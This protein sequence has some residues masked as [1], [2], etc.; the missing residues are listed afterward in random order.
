MGWLYL[1][2]GIAC[3]IVLQSVRS[4]LSHTFPLNQ[5]RAVPKP[6]AARAGAFDLF[7][8][9]GAEL[10]TLG[11]EGP[12]WLENTT[13]PASSASVRIHAVYRNVEANVVAWLAPPVD[14]TQPNILLTYFTSVLRDGRHAVTQLSDPYFEAVEDPR[15]PAQTIAPTG[16][17]EAL[18]GHRRFVD[19]FDCGTSPYGTSNRGMLHF[20]GEHM[21]GIRQRLLE[22]G[23]VRE[24]DG[25]ARPSL[26]FAAT[27]VWR[28]LTRPKAK[29]RDPQPIP[30]ERLAHLAGVV[31][32]VQERAPARGA[33]WG[34]LAISA[35]LFLGIGG[36]ILGLQITAIILGVILFHEAGHW[37]AMRAFGYRDPHITLLPLLGGV[38]MGYETDPSAAKRAWVSLAGPV[39][40]VILGWILMGTV[41]VD[42]PGVHWDDWLLM[43]ATILLV[44]NYLNI[45]P[46][47]PLDGSHVLRALLPARWVV[48]QI[49]AVFI[50]VLV[51]IIVA[52][53]L[54]FWVLGFIAA[55]QLFAVGNM[56]AEARLIRRLDREQIPAS[57]D[58]QVR[59]EW[60]LKMLEDEAGAPK[61]AGK[62]IGRAQQALQQLD[63]RPMGALQGALVSIVF[64]S[65]LVVPVGFLAIA[66][67]ALLL[68]SED[69]EELEIEY[70]QQTD[71]LYE[72][73]EQMSVIELAEAVNDG[74]EL[75]PAGSSDEMRTTGERLGRPLPEQLR[76]F[77]AIV[78]G[79]P[80][81]DI[82]PLD[83][84]VP[85]EAGSAAAEE[86][87]YL[88]YQGELMFFTSD[89]L[90]VSVPITQTARWWVIGTR[91]LDG[92]RLYFDPD[93]GPGTP[94]VY[95][96]GVEGGMGYRDMI[97]MLRDSWV[98]M[99][100]SA[101]AA[102]DYEQDYADEVARLEALSIEA[103]LDEFPE[104]SLL[105][106]LLTTGLSLPDP[107]TPA[108]I[109]DLEVRLGRSLPDDHRRLLVKHD[110]FPSMG[111]LAATDVREAGSLPEAQFDYLIEWSASAEAQGYSLLR[112]ELERC[113]VVAGNLVD[114]SGEDE[115]PTLIPRT[116][117]CPDQD[118]A[119][120]YVSPSNGGY[121]QDLTSVVRSAAARWGVIG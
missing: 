68:D 22:A 63:S 109:E 36:P 46:V 75:P 51:G 30:S 74:A 12:V 82:G 28:I 34:L 100:F 80:G 29:I 85:L 113:W 3:L 77:Y 57:E 9:A 110:G 102:L 88:Q 1:I 76:E 114:M 120:Q 107:A 108:A 48:L 105:E 39:P 103:L 24:V 59:L 13:E 11:F 8:Q 42:S 25:I 119:R 6:S 99:Q 20:A 32:G 15:T 31:T 118:P 44:I 45:L 37:A 14:V 121:F 7:D 83:E 4:V 61:I 21:N 65:F 92:T 19:G 52:Y 111:I 72:Q 41:F 69:W 2:V 54:D 106:R 116:L 115:E 117:W 78:N 101:Q 16:L 66:P 10:V 55:M 43:T 86:L 98:S 33:Q 23:K 53:V 104:R 91:D 18:A 112:Q 50:G 5:P 56:W 90:D 84:I 60:V 58:P 96:S 40:G 93:F 70:Q 95:L 62:R 94:S 47:P 89:D 79:L 17:G 87:E 97:G 35:A 73:A 26:R 67:A 71:A 38:T 64:L 27:M 81:L 49:G